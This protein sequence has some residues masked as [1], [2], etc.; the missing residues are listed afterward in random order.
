MN[1]Y[2]SLIQLNPIVPY[3]MQGWG[4]SHWCNYFVGM[5]TSSNKN[6]QIR[7]FANTATEATFHANRLK[8]YLENNP[9]TTPYGTADDVSIGVM[10]PI[11]DPQTRAHVVTLSMLAG[12]LTIMAS[13]KESQDCGGEFNKNEHSTDFWIDRC[14]YRK[15]GSFSNAFTNAMTT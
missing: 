14:P 8:T 12:N 9:V 4:K 5:N 3:D 1:D 6:I 2:G 15:Y 10:F 7:V 11:Y 13:S